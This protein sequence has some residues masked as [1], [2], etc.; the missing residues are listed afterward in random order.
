[1]WSPSTNCQNQT[2]PYPVVTTLSRPYSTGHRV[3]PAHRLSGHGT[4]AAWHSVG[5]SG[6]RNRAHR[7]SMARRFRT[8]TTSSHPGRVSRRFWSPRPRW[9]APACCWSPRTASG[10]V[11]RS[12]RRPGDASSRRGTGYRSTT[13]ELWGTRSGC[14]TSTP[15][16][17]PAAGH[18]KRPD[19]S[20]QRLIDAI[21]LT[22]EVEHTPVGLD[23]RRS[24]PGALGRLR[25]TEHAGRAAAAGP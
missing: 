6:A 24:K 15:G 12:N 2:S 4:M 13:Q 14:A 9:P 19:R 18:G 3:V 21:Q 25:R 8:W 17:R 11:A 16:A 5:T 10:R 1:M 22:G 7:A 23:Q 20:G